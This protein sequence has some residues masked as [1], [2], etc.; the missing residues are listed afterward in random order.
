[1]KKCDNDYLG[2]VLF[3]HISREKKKK[4]KKKKKRLE[5][6]YVVTKRVGCDQRYTCNY[7]RCRLYKNGPVRF[8]S[9]NRFLSNFARKSILF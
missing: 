9:K 5:L 7:I 4:K 3:K 8:S 2:N 6:E 1:M